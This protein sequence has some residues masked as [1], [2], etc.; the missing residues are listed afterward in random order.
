MNVAY[1]VTIYQADEGGYWAEGMEPIKGLFAQ[2]E[3]LHELRSNL[4]QALTLLLEV[5]LDE[6]E[7]LPR[8]VESSPPGCELIEPEPEVVAPIM[9]RWAREAANLTQGEVATRL[10][11]TQQA[12]AKLERSG[13]N[14]SVK[15][16]AKVARALGRT[17]QLAM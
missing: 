11:I 16:L 13:A 15:T 9:L 2:G 5:A 7:P 6:G 14:P 1:P 8:P 3:S 17:L 12:Y 4:R 10:G